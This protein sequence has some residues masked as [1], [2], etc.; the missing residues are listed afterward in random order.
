MS[1]DRNVEFGVPAEATAADH[2]SGGPIIVKQADASETDLNVI[3][4]RHQEMGIPIYPD[5]RARYGDFTSFDSYHDALNRI[6]E[7]QDE[8]MMLSPEL[9]DACEND[10]G[11]LLSMLETVEGREALFGKGLDEKA[12]PVA[13]EEALEA[14][15]EGSTVGDT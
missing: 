3:V 5:G 6:M 14:T 8:F 15:P 13:L 10:V 12:V 9:R 2:P 1:D 11:K 7:A 4:R